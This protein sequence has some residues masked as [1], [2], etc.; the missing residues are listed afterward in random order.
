M[1]AVYES[2]R[3]QNLEQHL[4]WKVFNLN[5][6]WCSDVRFDGGIGKEILVLYCEFVGF[7]VLSDVH[8]QCFLIRI[9]FGVRIIGATESDK[10]LC[11]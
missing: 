2:Y 11:E 5:V 7:E 8:A 10:H 1:L 3:F 6:F 9:C 4:C